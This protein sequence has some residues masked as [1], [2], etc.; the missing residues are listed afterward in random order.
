MLNEFS[1]GYYRAQM[2]IQEVERGPVIER[3]LYELIAR[4]IYDTTNAPITM[5]LGMDRGT[6]FTPVAENGVP[7]DVLGLPAP[8]IDESGVHPGTDAANVFVLK[9]AHA[10]RFHQTMDAQANYCYSEDGDCDPYTTGDT[11]ARR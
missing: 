7:T 9:P 8:L 4:R 2:N 5:R 11:R 10:Y 6:R 3:G 1:D